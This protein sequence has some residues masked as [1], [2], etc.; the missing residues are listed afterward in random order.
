VPKGA[1]TM[2]RMERRNGRITLS[3][4]SSEVILELETSDKALY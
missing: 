3:K 2:K 1:K 4:L